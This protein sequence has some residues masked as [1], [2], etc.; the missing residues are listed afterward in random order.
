MAADAPDPVVAWYTEYVGEPDRAVDIY[1][2]FGAFFAGLAMGLGGLLLFLAEG[3]LVAG[4]AFWMKEVAFAVGAFGLPTL[5]L[6]VVVLLPVDRRALYVGAAGT[7]V[8]LGAIGLFVW[9]YPHDWNLDVGPDYSGIGVAIYAVGLVSVVAASGTA[10]VSY[11][12]ERASGGPGGDA[13]A[14][15]TGP[16]VTDEQVR[17]DIDEATAASDLTWGGVPETREQRL[18]FATDEEGIQSSNFGEVQATTVRSSGNGVEDAVAGL[19]GMKGDVD[20]TDRGG[21]T[22]DATA[23]LADLKR[24]REAA[25]QARAERGPLERLRDRVRG[26][27]DR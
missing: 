8:T 20:R 3:A 21:S 10:L 9:A 1:A 24:K 26:L 27:L 7:L 18:T 5:L 15:E 11:H 6:G 4:E 2:G 22:D 23:K 19:K 13:A 16:E 14:A 25:E 17:A 12:V